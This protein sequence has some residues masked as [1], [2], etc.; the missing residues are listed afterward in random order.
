MTMQSLLGRKATGQTAADAVARR[1]SSSGRVARAPQ[2]AAI[3]RGR[4]ALRVECRDYP[5][6]AFED[7]GTYKEAENLSTKLKNAPRPAKPLKVVIAGAGLAG[8][9]CAK[10]LSDAGHIP[11]VLEGRDVLGGKVG[12]PVRRGD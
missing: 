11:I 10:Y 6:P 12:P 7:A 9:S 5:R 2:G 3:A 8:L 1:A 4:G